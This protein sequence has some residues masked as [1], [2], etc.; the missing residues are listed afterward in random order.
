VS[1]PRL[2]QGKKKKKNHPSRVTEKFNKETIYKHMTKL[3][4]DKKG[5]EKYP[6]AKR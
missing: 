2:W 5:C 6:K 1:P 4:R 3:R